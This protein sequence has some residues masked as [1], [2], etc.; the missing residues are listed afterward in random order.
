MKPFI[1]MITLISSFNIASSQCNI[2]SPGIFSYYSTGTSNGLIIQSAIG[3]SFIFGK[4]CNGMFTS[5]LTSND[6]ATFY[7]NA[8]PLK[9]VNIFPN[10]IESIL[11]IAWSGIELDCL[12]EIATPLGSKIKTFHRDKRESVSRIDIQG[13]SPGLYILIISNP[14]HQYQYSTKLLKL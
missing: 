8:G 1:L 4:A 9:Q 11:N 13:L 6:L 12:L 3:R 10:P 2:S 14:A 5:L 7:L